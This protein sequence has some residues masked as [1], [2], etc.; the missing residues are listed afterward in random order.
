MD[1]TLGGGYDGP[2][3][4]DFKPPRTEDDDGVWE[5]ARACMRNYLILREKVR[6]FRSDPEVIKALAESKVAALAEPT[7]GARETW[8]EVRGF[9]PDVDALGFNT[10]LEK[11]QS[12]RITPTACLIDLPPSLSESIRAKGWLSLLTADPQQ[13][14]PASPTLT[15]PSGPSLANRCTSRKPRGSRAR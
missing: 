8:R 1:S 14:R 3:H 13:W 6:A 2:V 7:L 5:S 10:L 4:F 12:L 9:T 11:L 15:G